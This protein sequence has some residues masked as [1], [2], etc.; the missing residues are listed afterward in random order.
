M[1]VHEIGPLTRK[2]YRAVE[3][4]DWYM[5]PQITHIVVS[6]LE[7]HQLLEENKNND[8]FCVVPNLPTCAIGLTTAYLGKTKI[9][10]D[11]VKVPSDATP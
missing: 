8:A 1:I 9:I 7:W 10:R 4:N 6:D 3:K 5:F 11:S 2:I